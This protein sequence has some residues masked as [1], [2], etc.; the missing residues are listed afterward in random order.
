MNVLKVLHLPPVTFLAYVSLKLLLTFFKCSDIWFFSF[1][2]SVW[3]LNQIVR[4]SSNSLITSWTPSNLEF[5]SYVE[6]FMTSLP[7]FQI[8]PYSFFFNEFLFC[9]FYARFCVSISQFLFLWLL[10]F[11]NSFFPSFP[12]L[13]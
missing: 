2:F 5:A 9:C 6:I 10:L 11:I 8:G 13:L 4:L 7:A 12:V 1:Y 3:T